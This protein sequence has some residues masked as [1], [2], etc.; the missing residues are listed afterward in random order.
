MTEEQ[1]P[2]ALARATDLLV[3]LA[4]YFK[5]LRGD[6]I[7]NLNTFLYVRGVNSEALAHCFARSGSC[8][9]ASQ[10]PAEAQHVTIIF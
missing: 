9:E 6:G 10:T 5:V 8:W 1:S 7:S 4:Y 2:V 3:V